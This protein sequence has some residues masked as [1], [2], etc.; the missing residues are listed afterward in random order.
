MK[1]E[2]GQKELRLISYV[3]PHEPLNNEI[4]NLLAQCQSLSPSV[5]VEQQNM[6]QAL[7]DPFGNWGINKHFNQ[8]WQDMKFHVHESK[9]KP[10][11]NRHKKVFTMKPQYIQIQAALYLGCRRISTFSYSKPT[12]YGN[13]IDFGGD[14]LQFYKPLAKMRLLKQKELDEEMNTPEF[15]GE[16]LR[17]DC[18]PSCAR[19]CFNV[20]L[21]PEPGCKGIKA[22]RIVP[23]KE[24]KT[25]KD[26]DGRF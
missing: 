1:G 4:M 20:I 6:K 8:G 13:E 5:T 24:F 18:L 21:L 9:F 10:L 17:I 3:A 16:V 12:L 19:I 14:F 25:E 15:P 22:D 2:K 11:N 26:Q 7:T 23:L